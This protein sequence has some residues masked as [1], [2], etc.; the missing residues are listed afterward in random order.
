MTYHRGLPFLVALLSGAS[1][2]AGCGGD[3][4]PTESAEGAAGVVSS[5]SS[6]GAT[7]SMASPAMSGGPTGQAPASGPAAAPSVEVSP[8]DG[9]PSSVSN[10]NAPEP[11]SRP[12]R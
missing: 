9:M 2:L 3:S 5:E 1:L 6:Q 4:A 12:A 8:G 7:T 11:T 10:D